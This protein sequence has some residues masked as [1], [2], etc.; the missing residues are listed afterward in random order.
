M[1]SL[2]FTWVSFGSHGLIL[3]DVG[4]LG[5]RLMNLENESN[6]HTNTQTDR[7]FLGCL[8][9]LLDLIKVTYQEKF[10]F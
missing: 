4:D 5:C 10:G 8:E 7:A 2:R 1:G 9:I 3:I 6:T